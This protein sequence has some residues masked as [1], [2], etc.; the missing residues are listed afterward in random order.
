MYA[1]AEEAPL[2]VFG[3]G[4][5]AVAFEDYRGSA[6][7]HAYPLPVPYLLYNGRFLKSDRDGVRG[8]LFHQDWV[9]INLSGNATTPVR[10]NNVRFGM[11]DLDSTVE[12]GPSLDF[13]LLRSAD[14]HVRFDLRL[15]IRGAAAVGSSPKFIGWTLSPRLAI[16]VTD[17]LGMHGWNLGLLGGPIFSDRRNNDYFYSVATQYA[18][19][20]R[21]AYEGAGGYAGSAAIIAVSKRFPRF[22]LGAYMRADTLA[23]AAFVDSPLV[24]TKAY[25]SAG[26]GFAWIIHS[27]SQTVHVS[28]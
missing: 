26:F 23:D 13:H 28:D 25:W 14:S 8:I 27:S 5:G 9:E 6:T 21:P 12:V 10:H 22:W 7:V 16:D 24:R 4:A 17:P 2:W 3:V 20:T 1:P 11:P 19:A 15:P 18:T